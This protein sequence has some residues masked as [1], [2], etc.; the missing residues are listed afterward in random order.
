LNR[1]LS[2]W[3]RGIAAALAVLMGLTFV[4]PPPAAAGTPEAPLKT[5]LATAVDAKVA[6]TANHAVTAAPVQDTA[7]G[8][9]G[10]S[11]PFFKTPA[12]IAAL[13]LMAGATT[14]LIA[15]RKS[16]D[17]VHSPGRN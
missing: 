14:W 3:A 13:V 10:E 15:S 17:V 9:G 16:S 5:T 6:A 2:P 12:G 11:K 4:A 7:G 1:Y 8:G